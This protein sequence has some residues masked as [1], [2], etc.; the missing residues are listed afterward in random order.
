[1]SSTVYEDLLEKVSRGRQ[2]Y[3]KLESKVKHLLERTHR[4]CKTEQEE[5]SRIRERLAPKGISV[6]YLLNIMTFR[7][8]GTFVCF[9]TCKIATLNVIFSF[10]KVY[11]KHQ[12]IFIHCLVTTP[13]IARH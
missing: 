2:F 7:I 3:D 12:F 4:V 6:F 10:F 9:Q 8:F 13:V 11:Y 5:R 1:M